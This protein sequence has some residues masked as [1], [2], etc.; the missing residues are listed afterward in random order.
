MKKSIYLP[1]FILFMMVVSGCNKM[2]VL[3]M[4]AKNKE[5]TSEN[6]PVSAP[7]IIAPSSCEKTVSNFYAGQNMLAGTITVT[8]DAVNMYVTFHTDGA[9]VMQ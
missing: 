1:S 4:S 9:W 2:E 5:T 7:S 8:N 3:P 6:T